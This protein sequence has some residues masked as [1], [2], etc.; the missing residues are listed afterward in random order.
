[1]KF[2]IAK[3]YT[4]INASQV[5]VG[6]K[7]YAAETLTDL[8]KYVKQNDSALLLVVT[9][10]KS[11]AYPNRFATESLDKKTQCNYQICYVVEE[12]TE[13]RC[14]Y[15]E[16]A[17]WVAKGEGV[18]T[19]GGTTSAQSVFTELTFIEYDWDEPVPKNAYL[20]R[21]WDDT[22]WHEPTKEYMG[23]S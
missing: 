13:G 18:W 8:K 5:K 6:S 14:T 1:M 12:P 15:K 10:I 20:I 23:I 17:R 7:V 2:D 21:K 4:A 9:D 16:L 22:G 11:E 3:V 19:W